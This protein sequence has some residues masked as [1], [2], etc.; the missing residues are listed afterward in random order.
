MDAIELL[1]TRRSIR[2]FKK[3]DIPTNTLWNIFEICRFS[4]TS[5]N[6]Q[7]YYFVVIREKEIIRKLAALRDQ[8]SLPI[9][10]ARVA[11]AIC[12]D[13]QKSKRY[14]QDACIAAYHFI[15]AAWIYGLGTCWIAAMDRKEVKELLKIPESHYVATVTP[16]GY[17]AYIP[18]PP[19][20]RGKEEMVKFIDQS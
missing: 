7:S 6:S 18:D 13:P 4:P 15:L 14:I 9:A 3:E 10:N 16:L 20:R 5:R 8:F 17:P 19:P 12:S 1:V 11:V 2:E